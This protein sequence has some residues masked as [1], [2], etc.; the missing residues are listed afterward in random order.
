MALNEAKKALNNLT[1]V[2]EYGKGENDIRWIT[3]SGFPVVYQ[4]FT[5]KKDNCQSTLR[6]VKGG[7]KDQAGRINHVAQHY[8]DKPNR[9]EYSAGIAPNYVHSQ[10]AAHMAIVIEALGEDFGA[11][12][13]SFSCHASDVP[14]LKEFTQGAFV[15]MYDQENPLEA[16]KQRIVGETH[17][18]CTVEV[19]PLGSLDIENVIGSRNFFS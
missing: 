5:T 8:T 10:D 12:H 9:Q 2:L 14:R 3:P 1:V 16:I 7:A 13:D 6:G 19:P 15:S 4:A 18:D 11:V 17:T